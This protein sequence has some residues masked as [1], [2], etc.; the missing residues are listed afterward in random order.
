LREE[1]SA[2]PSID[3]LISQTFGGI[4]DDSSD[5]SSNDSGDMTFSNGRTGEEYSLFLE[6]PMFN[7]GKNG[8]E[9]SPFDQEE[10]IGTSYLA[11]DCNANIVCVAAQLD[12]AFLKTNPYVRVL[13]DDDESWIRFGSNN[14]ETKL[15]E[16]NADEFKYVV[17]PDGSDFIIGYEGCWNIDLNDPKM[18]SIVNNFVE[19]H[20]SRTG[21]ETTSTGKPAS[22][23]KYICINPKCSPSTPKPSPTSSKYPSKSP[24]KGP[25]LNPTIAPTAHPTKMPSPSSTSTPTSFSTSLVSAR[26]V[27]PCDFPFVREKFAHNCSSVAFTAHDK[28]NKRMLRCQDELLQR[29][30]RS[31]V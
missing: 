8:N 31:H 6:L 19:V 23:G 7:G 1:S 2:R 26:K 25:V 20:F 3:G 12:E 22:N 27:C 14:G 10:R 28:A 18:Q 16:S 11:Y 24:T 29:R 9:G 30:R 13:Q 15:K 5:G 21:G 4:G 17:K